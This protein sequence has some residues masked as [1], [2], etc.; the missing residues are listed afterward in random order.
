MHREGTEL[1]KGRKKSSLTF[2]TFVTFV[3]SL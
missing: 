2:V 1:H 3:S